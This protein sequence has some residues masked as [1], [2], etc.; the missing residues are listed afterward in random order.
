MADLIK[1]RKATQADAGVIRSLVIA[2]RINPSGLNWRRFVVACLPDGEVIGCGQIKS[3]RDGSWEMASITV[4]RSW[5]GQGIARAMIDSLLSS[6]NGDLYLMCRSKHTGLYEGF[7]FRVIDEDEMP[8][9]FR[10]VK[11]L[12]RLSELLLSEGEHLVIMKR[13]V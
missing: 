13:A 2:G 5:R 3:H 7:G 6:F 12:A 10:K 1:I 11:Q 8:R 9:Y 4:K